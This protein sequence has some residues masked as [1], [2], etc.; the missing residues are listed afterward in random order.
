VPSGK[1]DQSAAALLT[2]P[3]ARRVPIAFFRT[4]RADASISG[5]LLRGATDAKQKWN[6]QDKREFFTHHRFPDW[7]RACN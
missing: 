2:L 7:N 6:G 5:L 1:W 3:D 4:E